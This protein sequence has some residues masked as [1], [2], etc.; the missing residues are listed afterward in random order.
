MAR[1]SIVDRAAPEN[2]TASSTDSCHSQ[3]PVRGRR[4]LLP[5]AGGG[6]KVPFMWMSVHTQP[7]AV[8]PGTGPDEDGTDGSCPSPLRLRPRLSLWHLLWV[9]TEYSSCGMVAF[10]LPFPACSQF[11]HSSFLLRTEGSCPHLP[12]VPVVK[13]NPDLGE[14]GSYLGPSHLHTWC[15]T[16]RSLLSSLL[17]YA[18]S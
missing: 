7:R 14:S 11:P 9:L 13:S 4:H 6:L 15:M 2:L 3:P 5:E 18:T 10:S 8:V 1:G 12:P 17:Q 16:S